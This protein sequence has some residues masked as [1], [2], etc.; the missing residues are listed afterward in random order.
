VIDQKKKR[1]THIISIRAD[2]SWVVVI[3]VPLT[4]F[5]VAISGEVPLN[6][7]FFDSQNVAISPALMCF[8]C[9]QSGEPGT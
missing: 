2:G 4:L 5:P 9:S 1:L 3:S 6:N 8:L 7:L